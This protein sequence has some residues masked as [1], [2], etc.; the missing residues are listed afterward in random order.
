MSIDVIGTQIDHT[1]QAPV[2]LGSE[3]IPTGGRGLYHVTVDQVRD[4]VLTY[5]GKEAIRLG[6]VDN[7]SDED[8][9]LSRATRE[10]LSKKLNKS[11][12]FV[13]SINGLTGDIDL[14]PTVLG[15]GN[16][17]NTSDKDKPLSEVAVRALSTKLD[18]VTFK[19][20]KRVFHI[21]EQQVYDKFT[22]LDEIDTQLL[23]RVSQLEKTDVEIQ[24]TL[25][26]LTTYLNKELARVSTTL[27]K[28]QM[29][30]VANYVE[31]NLDNLLDNSSWLT[32]RLAKLYQDVLIDINVV[33]TIT[34]KLSIK[35]DNLK[36]QLDSLITQL[37]SRFSKLNEDLS[38]I[39]SKLSA[40]ENVINRQFIDA[41]EYFEQQING[42][43]PLI[44][45][46]ADKYL[47]DLADFQQTVDGVTRNLQNSVNNVQKQ[48]DD[49]GD[50]TNSLNWALNSKHDALLDMIAS[51]GKTLEEL[52]DS[53]SEAARKDMKDLGYRMQ[54]LDYD[55]DRRYQNIE[56]KLETQIESAKRI[57][58]EQVDS[59]TSDIADVKDLAQDLAQDLEDKAQSL[60]NIYEDKLIKITEATLA[61]INHLL[62]GSLSQEAIDRNQAITDAVLKEAQERAEAILQ[63]TL[64]RSTQLDAETQ[65]LTE[66]FNQKLIEFN[67]KL[68]TDISTVTNANLTSLS[69]TIITKDTAMGSRVDNLTT[70]V[71]NNNSTLTSKIQEVSDSVTTLDTTTNSK[72]TALTSRLDTADN[73][74]ATKADASALS[75]LDTRVTNTETV[76]ASQATSLNSLS[77]TLGEVSKTIP[78]KTQ[79]LDLSSLNADTYYPVTMVVNTTL[80]NRII[81]KSALSSGFK[82]TWATHTSGFS[83]QFDWEVT[84][85]GCGGATVNR[86]INTAWY[87][88]STQPPAIGINQL[89]NSS[90][91][92]I[93]LRGGAKYNLATSANV[94]TAVIHTESVT[95]S[96]QTI[97]PRAY[98]ASLT[99]ATIW[100]E[101]ASTTALNATNTEVSRV[102]GLVTTQGSSIS[103]LQSDLTALDTKTGQ[104]I[105]N[106]A[107][108]QTTANTAVNAASANASQITSLDSRL[109]IA[110]GQIGN[111]AEA[112]ALNSYYT[113]TEADN[114]LAGQL[115]NFNASLRIGNENLIL[116]TKWK[117]PT[118]S[119]SYY[120]NGFT[121][122]KSTSPY[123]AWAQYGPF[124]EEEFPLNTSVVFSFKIKALDDTPLTIG[125]HF[126]GAAAVTT[127]AIDG[128][129]QGNTQWSSANITIPNDS[130][131]HIIAVFANRTSINSDFIY[132][133]PNRGNSYS[134]A[135]NC[136]VK[137]VML[138]LG[139]TY[140]EWVEPLEV[141]RGRL[142][143]NAAAIQSTNTEIT[144]IDGRVT[145]NSTSINS[146]NSKVATVEGTLVN[147]ADASVLN[148]YYTKSDA[149]DV[150][151]GKL[152]TFN[153]S[154]QIGGTNLFSLSGLQSYSG[155]NLGNDTSYITVTGTTLAMLNQGTGSRIPGNLIPV[156]YTKNIIVSWYPVGSYSGHQIFYA[157]QNASGVVVVGQRSKSSSQGADG[158][159]VIT[160]PS[161]ELSSTVTH[162]RLGLGST[163]N[164]TYSIRDVQVEQGT[165]VTAWSPSPRDIQSAIDANATAIQTTNTE[166]TRVN[167]LVTTQG[168]LI[169]GLRSDL[170]TV[171]TKAGTAINNAATAQTTANTAV[172]ANSVTATSLNT[173]SSKFNV[174]AIA[175]SNLLIN[176]NVELL[177]RADKAYPHGIYKLGEPWEVGAK[178]TLL[179]CATHTRATGDT[180]SSLAVY[181]GG[182]TQ[183]L[184]S[185]NDATSKVNTITFTKT[186]SDVAQQLNFYLLSNPAV[187]VATVATIHWAVLVKGD[188]LTTD[189]WI[190]SSYDYI[191]AS[192]ATN[193]SITTLSQT[194]TDAD[195]ALSNRI[196]TLS[197]TVSNNNTTVSGK[198]NDVVSSVSTLDAN[199]TTKFSTLKS[200]I[201][202]IESN[203]AKKFDATAIND[204]YTKTAA[205]A[206]ISGAFDSYKASLVFGG[207]NL[208]KDSKNFRIGSVN[209]DGA[210]NLIRTVLPNGSLQLTCTSAF[211]STYVDGFQS[212]KSVFTR[213]IEELK[214]QEEFTVTVWIKAV[215]V[216]NLPTGYLTLYLTNSLSYLKLDGDLSSLSS[217]K[218]VSFKHTRKWFSNIT[219]IL[220]HL[221][222]T[223]SSVG[224]GI[225]LT[226]W[227]IEKGNVGT[228]WSE[229]SDSIS[230]QISANATA[231]DTTN[232]EVSRVN[233]LV[234]TQSTAIT[235]LQSDLSTLDA[236][237]GTAIT[238]AATA[239]QTANTA[240]N[241]DKA[242]S[243][244]V[245]AL[246]TTVS[247]NNTTV[248]GK[249]NDVA[250]SVTTLE[251]NTNSKI[252]SLQSSLDVISS[253]ITISSAI[254]ISKDLVITNTSPGEI[255]KV[256]DLT[257]TG[258][259]V[260]SVGNNTGNDCVGARSTQVLTIDPNRMY[261]LRAR[262]RLIAGTGTIYLG[263]DC[264]N[265]DKSKYVTD[266]N[267]LSTNSLGSSHYLLSSARPNTGAWVTYEYF[268]QGKS[269]GASTGAGTVVDPREFAAQAAF[270]APMFIA[271]YSSAAGTVEI[272]YITLE[273][274]DDLKETRTTSTALSA[275]TTQV[276]TVDGNVVTL[277]NALT[278][279]Q[280]RATTIEG[281]L[282][283]KFD[284]TAISNY[285]TKSEADA[286]AAGAVNTFEAKLKIGA[287]NL[288]IYNSSETN[289]ADVST[290]ASLY[291]TNF[292]TGVK[293]E[294]GVT[295]VF[296]IVVTKGVGYETVPLNVHLGLATTATGEYIKDLGANANGIVSG[297]RV[298]IKFTPTTAQLTYSS[299]VAPY[300]CFRIRNEQVASVWT[301]RQM[302]VE[303]GTVATSW[304][305]STASIQEQLD[306]KTT[307][308]NATNTEVN[309]VNGLVTTQG[310]SINSLTSSFE[311]AR[312]SDSLVADYLMKTP[313]QWT[314]HYNYDLTSYFTTVTDGKISN[315][316]FRKP[317]SVAGCWNYSVQ[318]LPNTRKYKLSMWVR[319]DANSKG[320]CNFTARWVTPTSPNFSN[321]NYINVGATA[322]VPKTNTWTYVSLVTDQTSQAYTQ[323]QFGFA[324][325]HATAGGLWEMQGFKVEAVLND[326]D[327][328]SAKIA[329]KASVDSVQTTLANADSALSQR[330]DTL[331][332]TV[333]GKA[334]ASILSSYVTIADSNT[335][336][337]S[338]VDEFKSS[339]VIG[340]ENLLNNS[341]FKDAASSSSWA[342]NG[343][344]YLKV[345]DAIYG[346]VVQTVLPNG[347]VH[348]WLKLENDTSYVFSAMV[349][350]PVAK[351]MD[352]NSPLL[353]HS[354]L[355]NVNQ[356][357][358]SV[359]EKSH[360]TI[361]ADIWTR[362]WIRFK[363]TGDANSFRPFIYYSGAK[364]TIQVAWTKLERGTVPTDWSENSTKIREHTESIDGIKS[365]KTVSI[366]NNGVVAG[367]GLVSELVNGN[368]TSAFA[369]NADQFYIGNPRNGKKP[370]TV[371]TSPGTIN[372][373]SVPAGT[374]ID[375]AYIADATISSAKISKIDAN[376][377]TVGS[378][379][380]YEPGYNPA[381]NLQTAKDYVDIDSYES[382]YKVFHN[383]TGVQSRVSAQAGVLVIKTPLTMSAYMTQ[384]DISGYNSYSTSETLF[385]ISVGFYAYSGTT[386]LNTRAKH[387]GVNL[388]YIKLALDSN[389]KVV[390]LIKKTGNWSYP[391]VAVDQVKIGYATVSDNLKNNWS[392]AFE[393][394]VSAYTVN[395]SLGLDQSETVAGST[396]KVQVVANQ[397]SDIAADNKLT[398][399][400]KKS[401]KLI[402]DDIKKEYA[403]LTN[404]ATQVNLTYGSLT[405]AYN[406]LETYITPLLANTNITSNIV[407]STFESNFTSFRT[408]ASDLEKLITTWTISTAADNA[409][410]LVG[411]IRLG[412]TNLFP[413]SLYKRGYHISSG[414]LSALTTTNHVTY[415]QFLATGSNTNLIYQV[416]NDAALT[417]SNTNRVCFYNSS[418]TYISQVTIPVLSAGTP[419][420]LLKIAIPAS[421]AFVKLGAISGSNTY[422][423][424]IRIKFEFGDNPTDWSVAPE[425]QQSSWETFVL[426]NTGNLL[427]NTTFSGTV[428]KWNTGTVAN[429]TFLGSSVPVHA[430]TTSGNLQAHS[431]R[432][433][434]D[435]AKAYEVSVWLKSDQ[436]VGSL[437]LGLVAQNSS[438]TNIGVNAINRAKPV[439]VSTANTDFY[440]HSVSGGG[441][442]LNWV[443]LVG[444]IMPAG[445][446]ASDMK[447]LGS[448]IGVNARM[449]PQTNYIQVRWLNYYNGGTTTTKWAANFKCVEVDPNAIIAGTTAQIAVDTVQT[450]VNS[451]LSTVNDMSADNKLT[452]LEKQQ[453]KTIWDSIAN[454]HSNLL[455]QATTAGV[456][457]TAYTSAYNTLSTYLNGLFS[458]MTTSSTIV[459]TTFNTNFATLYTQ[460]SALEKAIN[461]AS[462]TIGGEN[463]LD[464]TSFTENITGWS[465]Y[466]GTNTIVSQTVGNGA[467]KCLSIVATA[468][469]QGIYRSLNNRYTATS[470]AVTVSFWA[471][472]SAANLPLKVAS[473]SHT[474]TSTVNLTTAWQ[475][476][477]LTL[478]KT[479]ANPNIVIYSGAAGTFYVSQLKY[480]KG[481]V[482]TAWAPST[483]ELD[484][485]ISSATAAASSANDKATDASNTV[486]GWKTPNATTID[487]SKITTG[488][489]TATQLSVQSLSALN[490]KIGTIT[491][492]GTQGSMTISDSLIEIRDASGNIRVRLGIW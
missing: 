310:S 14:V 352:N 251:G 25:Q 107:T 288:A 439:E 304:R 444:Y 135:V 141:V 112:S 411:N 37:N 201:S 116:K 213:M 362:I 142:V 238:N 441:N 223:K 19:D 101:K 389:N 354:G 412:G 299:T 30:L 222:V 190:P 369:I 284:S 484:A 76:N 388:D 230:E 317:S 419:Y 98:D 152:E 69:N 347:L 62:E 486:N 492:T 241:N 71:N 245:D 465:V 356:T 131:W 45:G 163:S 321:T 149:N 185:V 475:Y 469:N 225:I 330:I 121:L 123:T 409:E 47:N 457:S 44:K 78:S 313:S 143:A 49:Q 361:P 212:A 338:K 454:S 300:L 199:T 366:D 86:V 286:V 179:W 182:G 134:Q 229:S 429:Q 368:V 74:L 460:K 32:F 358:I 453:A 64:D 463:L 263:V 472:A 290:S 400:E 66:A 196:D 285:Y 202:T 5:F 423:N 385:N 237:A 155:G 446:P 377:I 342:S 161:S 39:D 20:F 417:S 12:Q 26:D 437:Y 408:A 197:S 416:W 355:D 209:S 266:S 111:K 334:D 311:A 490:A 118:F 461:D 375:T 405:S 391:M 403:E 360:T 427:N 267:T 378:S 41:R 157:T 77:S 459:R 114:V 203:V 75:A 415:D 54:E 483:Y 65:K 94:D 181:A 72:I 106:A 115:N 357:K 186:S 227:K 301:F 102:N 452:P 306:A 139:N 198:I 255:T 410:T 160:I 448:N 276:N 48:I 117:S 124:T 174:S 467:T 404:R 478:T 312:D 61:D 367:Y 17:D 145:A 159:V 297:E 90:R 84:G 178:Y 158:R 464:N 233:G 192:N 133:Q 215:D 436:A 13:R 40:N 319:C 468:A 113:K 430:L 128:V 236:K 309:R 60:V 22:K 18:K 425:D 243:D 167:G 270:A 279:L 298:V 204:Y 379:T 108:A 82:P 333:E 381:T 249:I 125:G 283:K 397:I 482:A 23:N 58:K 136:S 67:S 89:T 6:E 485:S 59:V 188:F 235:K 371:L 211:G 10:A 262:L 85:S 122:V 307:A 422:A 344:G 191:S 109:G 260:L 343:G 220:P 189:K 170:N 232:T 175:S 396:A 234:T 130:K 91:E 57:V 194:L 479:T 56:G 365:L 449:L 105:T 24:N 103:K 332:A 337:A 119:D 402:W 264:L 445:T 95:F 480:E 36:D 258:G 87:Q 99:I 316:V 308:I 240:V 424:N 9:P 137:D 250:T 395:L 353:C 489:I 305:P 280:G 7:T 216:T 68:N 259:Q 172:N 8:K 140:T 282:S 431:D 104:A 144:K 21:F 148:N 80:R 165:K 329:T 207:E 434:V 217:G 34:D 328:D 481:A 383:V 210:A 3:K 261:R 350:F 462:F 195:T 456:S 171:D 53:A 380:T 359:L 177:Y 257:A 447:N 341:D 180:T 184:Q 224:G 28:E 455:A 471:K 398:A 277:N 247:N 322:V 55:Y 42:L 414:N 268:L 153:T 92:Y 382:N 336:I 132:I 413:T 418:K 450:T 164:T 326:D 187:G 256:T 384:V 314:S 272:D 206:A 324:I 432:F 428:D 435:P 372:G 370:F 271:N 438:G 156:D 52:I 339:L 296:S 340:G 401:I 406:T 176:S 16:V 96:S 226:K 4:Y 451:V 120:Q 386:F 295:Y 208:I 345:S 273:F 46:A 421:A 70:T 151:A 126:L 407:R 248:T 440:F 393:T 27:S 275:L 193:A 33:K 392:I 169:S 470:A 269:A 214:D 335:A 363:L 246:T 79:I 476:Y 168:S 291:Y 146:L 374:Y 2:V 252:S 200:S 81:V 93:F 97:A 43:L 150:I 173:L 244:R 138:S 11:D 83:C 242:T 205:D 477:S 38:N 325:G 253:V 466:G 88:Y 293:L 265:S 287:T 166:V 433:T 127:V 443:K 231:I 228:D 373:V 387:S 221:T 474:G 320:A 315:T 274:A 154:L 376:K 458:S 281:N 364:E 162:L 348:S 303:E 327:I 488:S 346:S 351:A 100:S 394:D 442:P 420:Q 491:T 218:E 147:K 219:S 292:Y 323:L 318:S 254:D 110:E 15:L 473:D 73:Q 35:D 63:E 1:E 129:L 426:N 183:S 289:R 294:A 399:V 349:K 29:E 31:T 278:T 51:Q 390:I 50:L 331:S 239:Q 302:Q 487:G